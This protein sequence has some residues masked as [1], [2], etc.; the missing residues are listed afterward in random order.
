MASTTDSRK[1]KSFLSKV[2]PTGRKFY[3][4]VTAAYEHKLLNLND[5]K[6]CCLIATSF[7]LADCDKQSRW[8]TSEEKTITKP[9]WFHSAFALYILLSRPGSAPKRSFIIPIIA[10][11]SREIFLKIAKDVLVSDSA[12]AECITAVDSGEALLAVDDANET[13]TLIESVTKTI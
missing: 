10:T 12:G 8:L 2:D 11:D 3:T 9:Q 7:T 4:S 5:K 1:N 6:R 13:V